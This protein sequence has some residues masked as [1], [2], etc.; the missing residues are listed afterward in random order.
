MGLQNNSKINWLL[1]HH[2]PGTVLVQTWLEKQGYNRQLIRKYT[3]SK[4]LQRFDNGAFVRT[5][6]EVT[7]EGGV[8]AL[9]IRRSIFVYRI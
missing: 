8:Y 1:Q 9:Q 6:D 7:W 2:A 4:W 5:N 3:S